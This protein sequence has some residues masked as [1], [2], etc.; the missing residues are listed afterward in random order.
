MKTQ[1]DDWQR[2]KLG[3]CC[4]IVSGATPRRI[5]PEY[6]NGNIPWVTPKDISKL[7]GPV[8]QDSPEK[9]TQ[10][11]Y[12]NCSTTLLPKGSILFSS[13]API[14][15]VAIAGKPMCTNQGFKSLIPN[16]SVDSGYLYWCM[17]HHANEVAAKGNGT[18]FKEVSRSV[19]ND[20][21][22]P[23][24]PLE[25]Q[26]RIAAILDKA[27]TVRRKRQ[28]SI[29]LTEEFLRSV[30]LDM[31]GDPVTNPK[32]W[33]SVQLSQ[34]VRKDDRINYG[35]VQPGLHVK[36]GLPIV[37]VGD[38]DNGYINTLR[39]KCIEPSIEMKYK[40]SRLRG[41]EIL[42][43][44]VGS[45]GEVVL[46]THEL[47]GWNIVRAVARV[48]LQEGISRPYI[49]E[50]LRSQFVQQYFHKETRTV[51]QPTLNIQQI[52]ETPVLMPPNELCDVFGKLAVQHS[53]E[54][55]M[56]L[57]V[58]ENEINDLF[59]SLIQRAFTG[60]LG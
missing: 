57:R 55:V 50:Y 13:R 28:E 34:L 44:C 33:K 25:E 22:I 6:W 2:V 21:T 60:K 10:S 15:L 51:S 26:K 32:G 38:F 35:V 19:M 5:I 52:K 59:N 18:T 7:I 11:G 54:H 14:G 49:A 27:D 48:P 24:P 9:I 8:L 56:K 45:I 39:I 58:Y 46:V 36:G 29:R 47:A 17:K 23:L 16:S 30:L 37:R 1:P 31:F 43:A 3:D 53:D 20:F 40:R 42:I 12:E 41:D 4:E